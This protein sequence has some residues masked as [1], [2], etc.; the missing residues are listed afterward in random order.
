LAVNT[1]VKI[2]GKPREECEKL[3]AQFFGWLKGADGVAASTFKNLEYLKT[4]RGLRTYLLGVKQPQSIDPEWL[5]TPRSFSTLRGNWPEQSGGVDEKHLLIA[6][7][8][9]LIA[10]HA[11][12]AHFAFDIHDQIFYCSKAEHAQKVAQLFDEALAQVM[13]ASY[14]Q[15]AEFWGRYGLGAVT[16]LEPLPQ[17]QKFQEVK[18]GQSLEKLA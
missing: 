18:I 9:L 7:L 8:D 3:A 12:G 4:I 16:K 14:E 15:A 5:P 10:D 11:L 13:A 2:T 1:L 17:W 6:C